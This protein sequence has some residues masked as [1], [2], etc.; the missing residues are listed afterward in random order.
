MGNAPTLLTM[1]DLRGMKEARLRV[2]VIIPLLEAMGYQG[3]QEWHGLTERGKDGVCCDVAK[4]GDYTN[5]AVVA[6]R[7]RITGKACHEAARQIRQA[8]NVEFRDKHTREPRPV[9]IVWV[10]TNGEIPPLSQAQIESEFGENQRR[11]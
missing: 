8:L 11:Y 9:H 4:N 1:K 10:V 7:G 2:D 6:K 3:V 5:I